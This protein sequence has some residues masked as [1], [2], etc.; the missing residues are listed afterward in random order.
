MLARIIMS[1]R[2]ARAKIKEKYD[3]EM[4]SFLVLTSNFIN[5]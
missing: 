4:S 3:F 2:I 5:P 1:E